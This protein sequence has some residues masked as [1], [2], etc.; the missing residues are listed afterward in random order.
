MWCN[1]P[2]SYLGL[3]LSL[4]EWEDRSDWRDLLSSGGE[5]EWYDSISDMSDGQTRQTDISVRRVK[6]VQTALHHQQA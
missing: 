1:V 2:P 4:E 6:S 5:Y 3:S